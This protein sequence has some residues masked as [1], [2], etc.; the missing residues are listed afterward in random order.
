MLQTGVWTG[1][2]NGKLFPLQPMLCCQIILFLIMF[3]DLLWLLSTV[4]IT[5]VIS[6][7]FR[8]YRIK[9]KRVYAGCNRG[10]LKSQ[11]IAYQSLGDGFV[12]ICCELLSAVKC[13]LLDYSNFLQCW[14]MVRAGR[15]VARLFLLY[16]FF[17]TL[18]PA[19]WSKCVHMLW[20]C[21]GRH[22]LWAGLKTFN[23]STW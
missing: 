1:V 19:A 7:C 8:F 23:S 22:R 12:D 21:A 4:F 9:C 11:I 5:A 20:G 6:I 13:H 14:R 17:R 2:I 15:L 3:T 16:L 10:F 18:I